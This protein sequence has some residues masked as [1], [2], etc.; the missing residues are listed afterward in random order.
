MFLSLTNSLY[1][2]PVGNHK[3]DKT[4]VLERAEFGVPSICE[5]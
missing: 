3:N 4:S 2:K 1:L 5:G